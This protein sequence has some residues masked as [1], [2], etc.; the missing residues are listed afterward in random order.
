MTHI[1]PLKNKDRQV[2][3]APPLSTL[4]IIPIPK[5]E[6]PRRTLWMNFLRDLS[7]ALPVFGAVLGFL[8]VVGQAPFIGATLVTVCPIILAF[9][10]YVAIEARRERRRVA[11]LEKW[12]RLYLSEYPHNRIHNIAE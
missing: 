5:N 3:A 6:E 2:S 4:L 11:E 8:M 7:Y 1:V 12:Y 9:R 10:V